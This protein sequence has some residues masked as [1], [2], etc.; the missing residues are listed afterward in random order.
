MTCQAR[1]VLKV[2]G[3]AFR[4]SGIG[5]SWRTSTLWSVLAGRSGCWVICADFPNCAD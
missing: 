3:L 1:G 2:N 4:G 5:A